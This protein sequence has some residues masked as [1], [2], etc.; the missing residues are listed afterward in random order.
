MLRTRGRILL[1]VGVQK[2]GSTYLQIRMRRHAGALREQGLYVPVIP[3]VS[4]MMGNAKLLAT[5]LIGKPSIPF[6]HAFPNVDVPALDPAAVV[7]ELLAGWHPERETLVLS[8]EIL[9]PEHAAGVRALLPASADVAVVLFAR[10]QDRWIESYYRQ[11][12]KTWEARA[13]LDTFVADVL[14]R[15]EGLCHPDW[16]LHREAWRN[17]FGRCNVVLFDQAKDDLFSALFTAAGERVPTDIPDVPPQQVSLDLHQIAYLLLHRDAPT[18][19]EYVQ[20]RLASIEA[21]RVLGA[22]QPRSLLSNAT[23]ARLVA[24]FADSN[25][26]LL[27]AVGAPRTAFDMPPSAAEPATLEEIYASAGFREHAARADEI[28]ARR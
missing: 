1:H 11:L 24:A 25:R 6:A 22:P 7:A 14:A 20:R 5:A 27:D 4:A 16:W 21:S 28:F 13:D 8:A 12:V 15:S 2:T 17:A 26:R 23:R 9:R 19:A 3:V 10:R 18:F